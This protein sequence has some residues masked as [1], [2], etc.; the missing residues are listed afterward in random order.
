M[1]CYLDL[2]SSCV[3]VRT[4]SAYSIDAQLRRACEDLDIQG[5]DQGKPQRGGLPRPDTDTYLPTT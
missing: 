1:R 4:T 3:R 2:P 5:T